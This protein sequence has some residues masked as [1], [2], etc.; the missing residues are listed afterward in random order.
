MRK[1]RTS[2][3]L[4][5]A[6]VATAALVACGPEP[7]EGVPITGTLNFAT[8]ASAPLTLAV[9]VVAGTGFSVDAV[10]DDMP[11]TG[12]SEWYCYAPDA[13]FP[14]FDIE[15]SDGQDFGFF[16]SVNPAVWST[17]A[18]A[19]DGNDVALLLAG[20]D[21]YGVASS[22][23]VFITQAGEAPDT[24]GSNCGFDIEGPLALTG[25]RDR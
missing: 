6:A 16:L 7:K 4:L 3:L 24:A 13:N 12:S 2:L 9:G 23:T 22:G 14:N 20:K 5:P 10:L 15:A 25:E 21:R 8:G 18:H 19:I 11:I 1:I 17:G